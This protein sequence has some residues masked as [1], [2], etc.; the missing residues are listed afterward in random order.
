MR[1]LARFCWLEASVDGDE[2][3]KPL[4][5]AFQQRS[6]FQSVPSLFMHGRGGLI[7]KQAFDAG[8]YALINEDAHSKS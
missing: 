8:I 7:G 5:R 1:Y 4:F 6:V 2:Y 3:I